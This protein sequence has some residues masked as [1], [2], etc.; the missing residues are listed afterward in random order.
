MI[1][2]ETAAPT[3]TIDDKLD[4]T[5]SDI[6]FDYEAFYDLARS[7]DVSRE[8][9]ST[10]TINYSA[11]TPRRLLGTY[12]GS[13]KHAAIFVPNHL[14]EVL[15]TRSETAAAD[16]GQVSLDLSRHLNDTTLHETGHHVDLIHNKNRGFVYKSPELTA[17]LAL[18]AV[19]ET[20]WPVQNSLTSSIQALAIAANVAR[21]AWNVK[22]HRAETKLDEE[23]AD[24]FE[25]EHSEQYQIAK[26]RL[27]PSAIL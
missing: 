5:L 25:A 3:V 15:E 16:V 22:L 24:G 6:T 7:V 12:D 21:L 9:I 2:F 27:L 26:V 17:L 1:P 14:A 19:S 4:S 10:L 18:F 11:R 23:F 20:V 8:D 13:R